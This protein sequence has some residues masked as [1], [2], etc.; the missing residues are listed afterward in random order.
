MLKKL[1]NGEFPLRITFWK[2]G[3]LCLTVLYYIHRMFK[4]LAGNYAHSNTWLNLFNN[5]SVANLA[6]VNAVWV[7]GYFAVTVFL[8]VYSYGMIK[9]IWRSAAAYDKSTWLAQLA[10]IIIVIIIAVIW[11]GIIKG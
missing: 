6:K 7:L 11:Y 4:S 9:G 1:F 2:Y 5:L 3:V 8:A 10:K